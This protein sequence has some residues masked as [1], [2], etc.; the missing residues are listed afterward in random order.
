MKQTRNMTRRSFVKAAGLFAVSSV[1]FK[2]TATAAESFG[3]IAGKPN[4]VFIMADDLGYGDVGCYGATKIET[5]NIDRIAREGMMFTD[6]HTP[7]AVCS[8]TRYGVLTGRYCWRTPLKNGPLPKTAGLWFKEDRMTIASMLKDAGYATAAI[9]K[10]HLGI[11][12]PRQQFNYK[13]GPDWNDELEST[14]NDI[15]FDYFY[16]VPGGHNMAPHVN[17]ENRRVVG[18]EPGLQVTD[19]YRMDDA[20]VTDPKYLLEKQPYNRFDPHQ[21][22]LNHTRR[23]IDFINKQ[24]GAKPFYLYFATT[25][26]H[27]PHTPNE[28]FRNSSKVGVYGDYVEEL[29]WVVGQIH[30]TL[31]NRGQIDNTLFIFTSDNGA[32]RDPSLSFGHH[33]NGSWRGQK[34]DIW[35]GGHRVP[36]IASWP[37]HIKSA[38]V[39]DEM[40][41]LTDF[42]PTCAA[43]TGKD[44]PAK[45]AED[46]YNILPYLL[47]K[48]LK[49]PIRQTIVHH[50][51][52]GVFAIRKGPWKL[53][54][55]PGSGGLIK[56][57]RLVELKPG[58]PDGQLYNLQD[59]PGETNNLFS[60]HPETVT[61]LTMLLDKYKKQ[62]HSKAFE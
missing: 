50:S 52:Y 56:R 18:I 53:C 60:K 36:F 10:W 61:Q 3:R 46:G 62:G 14:P 29:D 28:V 22:T 11:G 45:A 57:E 5:P 47:G 39:C 15:G 6:A 21:L 2:C 34:G 7:S 25:N 27:L 37:G 20:M 33:A 9:G 16:G 54:L 51:A 23:A 59:D 43:L 42:M 49:E 48:K 55:T 26:V 31:V 44:I 40:I 41:C 4:I 35:E 8:P 58:Q 38:S 13:N 17:I 24:A 1:M 32:T 19:D 12:L 30:Q